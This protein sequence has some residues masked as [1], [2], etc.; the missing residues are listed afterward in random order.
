MAD[1]KPKADAKPAE[2]PPVKHPFA[3]LFEM[4][5]LLFLAS[6]VLTSIL[7]NFDVGDFLSGGSSFTSLFSPKTRALASVLNP[8]G[9]RAIITSSS[10]QIYGEPGGDVVGT[11]KKNAKGTILQ[12]PVTIDG[13][14]Y[15]YVDFD[16]GVDGWVKETD[17]QYLETT[18]RPLTA[19]EKEGTRVVAN[20]GLVVFDTPGGQMLGEQQRGARGKIVSGPKNFGGAMYYY[21]DFE[22][23]PD[24]WVDAR[25]LYAVE[26]SQP[27]FLGRLYMRISELFGIIRI[28]FWIILIG[29]ALFILYIIYNTNKIRAN[30]REKLY[31]TLAVTEPKV[32][33][34]SAWERVRT[35]IESQ[36]ESDWRLAVIEADIMLSELVDTMGVTGDSLGDKLKQI[37]KSDFVTL[38]SAW[39][40]HK[41]RNQIAHDAS[42]ILTQREAKRVIAL[43]EEVFKEFSFI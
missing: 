31:P 38:D 34:N 35:H 20:Q 26:D 16:S 36:N 1:E 22:N 8:I 24:G 6:T 37:E 12:G 29:L 23:G 42:Y 40:A 14:R 21:V 5:L 4:M 7:G 33:L 13:V 39:E 19:N 3:W 41:V 32:S 9:G 27:G 43:Y 28:V 30:M 11:Q 15:Y 17:A 10:A 18:T 2:T 25:A